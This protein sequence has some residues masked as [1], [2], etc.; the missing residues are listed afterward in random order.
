ME[1]KMNKLLTRQIKRHFGSFDYLPI[2]LKGIINDINNT[3]NSF[4]DDTQLLQ[5]SIEISSQELRIAFQKNRHDAETQ[6]ET[7]NK[8]KEVISAINPASQIGIIENETTASESNSLFD[9][10][11]R[12]IEERKQAEEEILKLSKAVEQNPASIVITDIKGNIEYVNPK[13]C[14]LTGYTKEEAI[15]KNP[16]ILKS[17]TSSPD[18]FKELWTTILSG[19]EWKG[20]FHNKKKNG[21]LFWESGAISAVKNNKG[22]IVNFLAIKE[23]ITERKQT[24][25]TLQNERSLFRT[26]IDLIP[27][28]VYVKD[29]EGRKILANPKEVQL[30]GRD[31]ENEIIGKTDSD[32][33]P[34]EQARR[35]ADEDNLVIQSGK[36]ILNIEGILTDKENRLHSLLVSKVPLYDVQGKI[37]GLIGVTH[38][39]TER[40]Q[41]ENQL[42]ESENLQRILLENVAVGIVIIDP[43]TRIIENINSFASLL[44]GESSEN[45][46]GRRCHLFM[47]PAQEHCCP[48]CDKNQ[49]VENSERI[50]VRADKS[51]LEILKT[52]K[53]IQIGGKDKLLESFVDIA[54]QKKAEE[55]L[56][57]SNKKWEAII[58]ASPDGI[59]MASIDGKIQLMSDK[60]IVMYGYDI[61]RKDEYLGKSI[62][63]FID[64]S[65]HQLLTD[66]FGR[67]IAGVSEKKITEYLAIKKD[68][69]RF[70]V[71]VNSTVLMDSEGNPASILF[72]ERDI[73]ERK[74]AEE[75]LQNERLLLRTLINNIPDLIY[76][77]DLNCRKT[78]VNLAEIRNL[79]AKSETE[80][81]GKDDFMFYPKELAE[82]FF[83][84][85]K[86]VINTGKQLINREEWSFDK[87]KKKRWLL[88][89][90]LPLRSLDGQIIGLVGIGHDITE[91]KQAEEKLKS[92]TDQIELKNHELDVALTKAEEAKA[93]ANEMT[94][95]A[96]MANKAKSVFLANMSHEIRTPLNAIIGF[97]QLM[98][99]DEHLTDSQKEHVISIIHAGEHLLS[100]IN[101]IL[102]LSKM[103]AGRLE[104]NPVN[105]DLYSLF[106]DIKLF[107]KEQAQTKH[108]QFIFETDTD[109][110]QYV[111][112]DDNKLRRIYINLIGNAIKFTNEGGIAVRTRLDKINNYNSKLIVEI[113]DS[114]PGISND[115]LDK[116]FKHFVQ[117]S[118]GI[119]GGSGS[120]LGL[121]LSRELAI[122]MGGDI[123]VTSEV[124]K[125]SVFTFNVEIEVGKAELVQERI[126][127]Q[128]IG[129][130]NTTESYRILVVD[131]KEENLRV[132][133]SLLN[134]VGF[135]TREAVNGEDAIA[136][137]KEWNPHLILMDMRMPVMDGY[138]ATRLI[139]STEKGKLI[140]IVALT[141][142]SFEDERRKSIALD[143]QGY[144]RKPFRESELF[145]TIGNVLGV[146]Y[147]YKDEP[148]FAQEKYL[149]DKAVISKDIAK[150]HDKLLSQMQDA[151]AT[152]DLDLLIELINGIYSDNSDLAQHL[153]ALAKNYDYDYLH[154]ILNKKEKI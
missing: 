27:N 145:G 47:C 51:T 14:D 64:P 128:L 77:K 108:L 114:G 154:Q 125:G 99:R 61:D 49:K 66:N 94:E 79:G 100:L 78:L 111:I 126:R 39:I 90:K 86:L 12:L 81:L 120:G 109:L 10:L 95:Q 33:Y 24:E 15:G 75:T 17:D 121:A 87:N 52:V 3:Y 69:R 133:V 41:M 102:E 28:A 148:S 71:D 46:I 118:S 73:T 7:I 21:D 101:D 29:I 134:L 150:L 137:F 26:I 80:V 130:E 110:P 56:M 9:A 13:F 96:E 45:I 8:I 153:M 146:K 149:D 106:N 139:K 5:N 104:L 112:V 142:S 32:L 89:S 144:I 98:N 62:F 113:Q 22:E 25:E 60:L 42:K 68:K 92:Y 141:A 123:S 119:S 105:I 48:V 57:Q 143:M 122:L 65:N 54:V 127:K 44:I 31:S 36:P 131:D 82:K 103:E 16:R 138:E 11:I 117:T 76:S 132:V 30:T 37:T 84:D 43:E 40:K 83:A 6:N 116:L 58:S 97:S 72:V 19:K 63:D 93:K 129:Y 147:I 74:R 53:K 1:D 88:T 2:E 91:R 135:E 151:I 55:A 38:D 140:P 23:D 152:A 34:T 124:G 50:L 20:E 107:F 4:E 18:F 67:L 136:K 70:Y 85:D 59:G 35:S 115:E